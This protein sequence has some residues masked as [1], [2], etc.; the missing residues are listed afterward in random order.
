MKEKEITILALHLGT[1]G[2]ERAITFLG[3]ILCNEYK[4]KIVCVYKLQDKPAFELDEK[5]EVEYLSENI[6]P[7]KEKF[8][9]SLK[10][11][12]LLSLI[13][14]GIKSIKILH[15]K[16]KR[17]ID[18]IKNIESDIV[19]STRLEFSRW[20]GKYA[21]KDILKIAQEHNHHNDDKRTIKKTIKSLKNINYFTPVSQELT[22]FYA[23][24]IDQN[25][26]K[27]I[28]IP[29]G[30]DYF[31]D[32]TSSLE[33]KNIV[34]VGRLVSSKGF[35]E[36]IEIFGEII[37]RE[38][39][40]NLFIVGSGDQHEELKNKI[41]E[42]NLQDHIFLLGNKNQEELKKIFLDSS[43][44]VMTSYYESFGLVLIEAES[45]GIPLV[46]FDSA[47]G[48]NEIIKEDYNGFLIKDRNK[49][50][51]INKILTLINDKE[52]RN[53]IGNNGREDAKTYK[54]EEIQKKWISF[55]ND[56]TKADIKFGGN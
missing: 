52:Y 14:E 49:Q 27:C 10:K 16:K 41:K 44:Y 40:W 23:K 33:S 18:K 37:L 17:M 2:I 29:H 43:I 11:I 7:N 55:L 42:L 1:G 30:L 3:N 34:S 15:I 6:I 51:M 38:K 26:T 19:I 22:E 31:P 12:K 39:D 21:K 20:V 48:A 32:S 50:E 4:I 35:L 54:K 53:R 5:I 28:Y 24:K 36:L 45:F 47:Q 46:A 13:K 9:L 56:I 8:L 25:K